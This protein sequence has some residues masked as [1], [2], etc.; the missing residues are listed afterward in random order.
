MKIEDYFICPKCKSSLDFQTGT[1]ACSGCRKKYPVRNGIPVFVD[2]DEL[3]D[4]LKGQIEYFKEEIYDADY[5]LAPWQESYVR[6]FRK[7]FPDAEGK[8]FVDI[9]CGS[10]YMAVEMAKAGADVIA[11]DL[12]LEG[13]ARLKKIAEKL[14]LHHRILIAC[15]L[16]DEIPLKDNVADYLASN[17]VIEHIP[18]EKKAISEF[19][20]ILRIRGGAMIAVPLSYR[21]LNPMLLPVNLIHDR[22]I[23]HLRRY[24]RKILKKKFKCWHLIK[25]CYTGHT[26]KAAKTLFNMIWPI[27]RE[28]QMEIQDE[29]KAKNKWWASNIICLF[30]KP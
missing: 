3:D 26:S 19:N 20:R 25:T 1:F 11:L 6:K 13:L 14:E 28:K 10:G 21:Y 24:D 7:S 30:Q 2:R 9:G 8:L 4:H 18:K 29:K 17:A 12:N 15:S 27:F 16:A 22:R 23:G 5:R